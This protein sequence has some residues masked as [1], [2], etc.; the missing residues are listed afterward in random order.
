MA[1]APPFA[2]LLPDAARGRNRDLLPECSWVQPI[3]VSFATTCLRLYE[4]ACLPGNGKGKNSNFYYGDFAMNLDICTD[5]LPKSGFQ[6]QGRHL[7]LE[8]KS[9]KQKKAVSEWKI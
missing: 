1:T 2:A 3:K 5:D 7:D 4:E 8:F 9:S 6:D